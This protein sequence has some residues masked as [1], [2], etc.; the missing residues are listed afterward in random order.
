MSGFERL[1]LNRVAYG[2]RFSN[3][4]ALEDA[5]GAVIDEIVSSG[6]FDSKRFENTTLSPGQRQLLSASNDETVT[7]TRSDAIF[8]SQKDWTIDD[9][10]RM[11][12]EFIN[13]VWAALCNHAPKPPSVMRYG[14]LIGFVV[15]T[16]W[17]PI[18]S[19]LNVEPTENSELDMR[20]SRRLVVEE[21]LA[22]QDVSDYRVATTMLQNRG[23]ETSA[24]IDFQHYFVPS[25]ASD[26]ARRDHP[27]TR[28]V[29]KALAYC[30]TAGWEFLQTRLE[31]L[32]RAA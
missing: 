6:A 31:R 22:L 16:Q 17:N 11:A 25:L 9:V 26:K 10:S 28:F 21:A 1:T 32:P 24:R 15:P 14:C 20:Y 2:I 18:K 29:D 3:Q 27:Y 4:F 7:L 30:R 8:A 23:S 5:L 12:D 13:V 19:I